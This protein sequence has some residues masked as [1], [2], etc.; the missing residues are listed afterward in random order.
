[1]R[2]PKAKNQGQTT[3]HR[4]LRGKGGIGLSRLERKPKESLNGEPPG[5][6][7]HSIYTRIHVGCVRL[8]VGLCTVHTYAMTS[9]VAACIAQCTDLDYCRIRCID[10]ILCMIRQDVI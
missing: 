9:R 2:Q 1:M 6:G 8:S 4:T 7:L 10:K 3:T 5:A